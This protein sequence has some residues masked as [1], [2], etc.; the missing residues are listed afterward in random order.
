MCE[1]APAAPSDRSNPCT[2]LCHPSRWEPRSMT[3][4]HRSRHGPSRSQ[5]WMVRSLT[6][7]ARSCSRVARPR[8]MRPIAAAR[9]SVSI[10]RPC[11]TTGSDGRLPPQ[12]LW[13]GLRR[14]ALSHVTA[15]P[16]RT[17][18]QTWWGSACVRLRRQALSHVTA[19]PGRTRCQTWWWNGGGG[20]AARGSPGSA[21]VR[22]Q[23]AARGRC[24]PDARHAGRRG[25]RGAAGGQRV[26]MAAVTPRS[27]SAMWSA[28]SGLPSPSRT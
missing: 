1:A 27:S 9:R 2:R 11:R 26:S 20:R 8:W 28:S 18:C 4:G 10:G 15:I 22:G 19:I 25:R 23:D 5:R 3:V 12:C 6:P 14:Q 17:R 21:R 16:G 13:T 7:A 24:A